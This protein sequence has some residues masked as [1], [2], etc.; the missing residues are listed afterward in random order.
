[1]GGDRRS[2]KTLKR[3]CPIV[4]LFVWL[5]GWLVG[6]LLMMM[7]MMRLMDDDDGIV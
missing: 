5:V 7:M 1:M 4:L 6:W 2:Y 3:Y